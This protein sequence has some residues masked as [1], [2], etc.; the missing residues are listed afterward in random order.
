MGYG[1]RQKRRKTWRQIRPFLDFEKEADT[2][3]VGFEGRSGKA[4]VR[5]RARAMGQKGKGGG[6]PRISIRRRGDT[7]R[8]VSDGACG[9][10]RTATVALS[11]IRG[12][13][14]AIVCVV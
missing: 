10:P 13:Y 14:C 7:V 4:G 8:V 12:R 2:S 1:G 5:W 11:K 6:R 9:V 3:A